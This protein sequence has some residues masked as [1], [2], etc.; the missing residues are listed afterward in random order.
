[1][2]NH[3][4]DNPAWNA[5][6]SGNSHLALGSEQVKFFPEDIG[7]FA[8]LKKYDEQSFF[9]LYNLIPPGRIIAIPNSNL[10]FIPEYWKV[11][12]RFD[13]PQ[14]TFN[15]NKLPSISF[16]EIVPLTQKDVMQMIALTKLTEPG[17]FLKRTIEFGNYTGIFHSGEL[18]AMAG[19]RMHANEYIEISAVCT[20][21][22]HLGK[23]YGSSLINNQVQKIV[24]EGNIPFLHVKADNVHAINLYKR[25]G[26]TVR[27]NINIYVLEKLN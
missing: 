22:D 24:K 15:F 11:K 17:P 18:V 4:L 10:L 23:G 26:F 13:V 19:Q 14:L 9:K 21:P 3:V 6:L 2:A 27:K 8:G 25:L 12:D 7:P 20:H 5:M 16:L 1:M